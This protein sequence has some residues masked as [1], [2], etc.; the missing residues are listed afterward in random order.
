MSLF[1]NQMGK[2]IRLIQEE[3]DLFDKIIEGVEDEFHKVGRSLSGKKIEYEQF[4]KKHE[5]F[6]GDKFLDY[7]EY[8]LKETQSKVDELIKLRLQLEEVMRE[9]KKGTNVEVE[10][11]PASQQAEG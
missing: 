5:L 10:Y 1:F 7:L 11:A 8:R 3:S 2:A 9:I 6:L 4:K